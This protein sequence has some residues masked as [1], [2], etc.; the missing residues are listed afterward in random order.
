MTTEPD[1][2]LGF[3]VREDQVLRGIVRGLSNKEIG[4]ELHISESAVKKHVSSLIER[5]GLLNRVEIRL[6]YRV[7]IGHKNHEERKDD[8][9]G[10]G[11][12]GTAA[13]GMEGAG[14][15]V[16]GLR[17]ADSARRDAPASQARPRRRQAR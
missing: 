11:V 1:E 8:P 17:Q 7:L 2:D 5:T 13:Q 16:R 4:A 15:R 9:G 3:T 12:H 6:C 14:T 10:R